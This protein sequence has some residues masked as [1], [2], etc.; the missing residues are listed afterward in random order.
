MSQKTD[1]LP[2]KI[3]TEESSTPFFLTS[4]YTS[5]AVTISSIA[6]PRFIDMMCSSVLSR[7]SFRNA[8][9][10][11]QL[12]VHFRY[13]REVSLSLVVH[14]LF[15]AVR[16]ELVHRMRSLRLPVQVKVERTAKP[17]SLNHDAS[18]TG[19][20]FLSIGLAVT[21]ISEFS[22]ALPRRVRW[23]YSNS[24]FGGRLLCIST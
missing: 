2:L 21:T 4:S 22:T 11:A 10:L 9:D 16:T 19:F 17:P 15:D 14:Q 20:G 23:N 6:K 18:I 12:S 24:M 5:L 7:S 8:Y 3:I 13:I 1:R